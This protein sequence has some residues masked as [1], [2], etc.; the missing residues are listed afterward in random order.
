M[1]EHEQEN[2]VWEVAYWIENCPLSEEPTNMVKRL[3][4]H[5]ESTWK[6]LKQLSSD[7]KSEGDSEDPYVCL[8]KWSKVNK[9]GQRYTKSSKIVWNSSEGSKCSKKSFGSLQNQLH[10]VWK[11]FWGVHLG[12]VIS[13]SVQIAFLNVN[14][15]CGLITTSTG[16]SCGRHPPY[17]CMRLHSH[18]MYPLLPWCYQWKLAW[19]SYTA[20]ILLLPQTCLCMGQCYSIC[21]PLL[22]PQPGLPIHINILWQSLISTPCSTIRNNAR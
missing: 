7:R 16:T 20:V 5:L 12:P 10:N 13:Q 2:R 15:A 8:W 1:D 17:M 14:R 18:L 11:M 21:F 9:D 6:W 3:A 22:Q 19:Q 4:D